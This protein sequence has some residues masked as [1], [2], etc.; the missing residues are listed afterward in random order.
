M[1]IN[2]DGVAS[3]FF[4]FTN[5]IRLLRKISSL[6]KEKTV[7][8]SF[9]SIIWSTINNTTFIHHS[10]FSTIIS[11]VSFST[12]LLFTHTHGYYF[13][14][15]FS[16]RPSALWTRPHLPFYGPRLKLLFRG[17]HVSKFCFHSPEWSKSL[18]HGP[19][20]R[21]TFLVFLYSQ[22][23]K[24]FNWRKIKYV[25]NHMIKCDVF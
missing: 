19:V 18:F 3:Q 1:Q 23:F 13:F 6:G 7:A 21:K 10:L 8:R 9:P 24:L 4:Q 12:S 25:I 16:P 20:G 2:D 22:S 11:L 15:A 14:S 5:L 17:P